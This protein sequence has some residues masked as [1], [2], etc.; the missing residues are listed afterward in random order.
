MVKGHQLRTAWEKKTYFRSH[1]TCRL[2]SYMHDLQPPR[3]YHY[4]CLW[5]PGGPSTACKFQEPGVYM[6]SILV[7][8]SSK[9]F[10]NLPRQTSALEDPPRH[11]N[12]KIKWWTDSG[13][14]WHD[15]DDGFREDS[16]VR[17]CV[18]LGA[19]PTFGHIILTGRQTYCII[20]AFTFSMWPTSELCQQGLWERLK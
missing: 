16:R 12:Q 15:S 7:F 5:L 10:N 1:V 3:G 13:D 20:H 19:T 6:S 17:K 18:W 4:P 8:I 9:A 14:M 11:L 2:L